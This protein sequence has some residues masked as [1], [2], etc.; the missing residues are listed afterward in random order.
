MKQ[1]LLCACGTGLLSGCAVTL[2]PHTPYLPLIRD[3]GQAE[4]RVSTGFSGNELQ[5]GYQV[6]DKL[7]VHSAFLTK[8]R[9]QNGTRLYSADLGL[10]YYYSSPN[11][12]WRFGMHGGL[13]S[14]GGKSY[15][16]G[17]GFEG[18]LPTPPVDYKVRYTYAYVQPT[19]HLHQGRHT[20]S[21]GLRM[22]RAYYHQ[23]TRMG[24]DTIGGVV[25]TLDYAGAQVPFAQSVLQYGYRVSPLVNLSATAGA[26]TLLPYQGPFVS[27]SS[28]FIGQVGVHLTLRELAKRRNPL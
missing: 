15:I 27:M 12:F 10:G 25:N 26:Q 19:V 28:G 8:G 6:T 2:A 18:S 22:S 20:W 23:F 7:I 1:I 3:K 9:S 21:F 11:G 16:S 14:G 4:A 5:L 13:A 24:A 17:A